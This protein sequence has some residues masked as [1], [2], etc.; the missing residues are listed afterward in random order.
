MGNHPSKTASM[1]SLPASLDRHA[2]GH[3]HGQESVSKGSQKW[4]NRL[5]VGKMLTSKTSNSKLAATAA[6]ANGVGAE[7]EYTLEA[8]KE[9][10]GRAL[11]VT[12]S[13]TVTEALAPPSSTATNSSSSTHQPSSTSA[14]SAVP[15]V[16]TVTEHHN[17]PPPQTQQNQ[18]PPQLHIK[19]PVPPSTMTPAA[20]TVPCQV[21]IFRV[22]HNLMVCLWIFFFF[23]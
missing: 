6:A 15:P 4:K 21:L 7:A 20:V 1:D 5:S 2:V 18:Q 11:G 13:T 16:V 19:T 10:P 12:S 22:M 3:G 8:K 14:S 17:P 23:I 9:E